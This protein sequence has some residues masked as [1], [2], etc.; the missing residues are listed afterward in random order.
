MQVASYIFNYT[1]EQITFC[2]TFTL[3]NPVSITKI[4]NA[5]AGSFYILNLLTSKYDT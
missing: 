2:C 5:S 3:M 4:T 1:Y